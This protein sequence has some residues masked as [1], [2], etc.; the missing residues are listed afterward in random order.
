MTVLLCSPAAVL[1]HR[2]LPMWTVALMLQVLSCVLMALLSV[3]AWCKIY[4]YMGRRHSTKLSPAWSV[5]GD[6]CSPH[7]SKSRQQNITRRAK[8]EHPVLLSMVL[9]PSSCM[10]VSFPA[11]VV[12]VPSITAEI[13]NSIVK[14]LF[15]KQPNS[16]IFS[17][18]W[19]R[20]VHIEFSGVL[21]SAG[22]ARDVC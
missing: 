14:Q 6:L 22:F 4:V 17:T 13:C 19:K 18:T 15:L 8:C 1:R 21:T 16:C 11:T 12:T 10:R 7:C 20:S 3:W 2:L 9:M 5:P